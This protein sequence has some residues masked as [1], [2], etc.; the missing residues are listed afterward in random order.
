MVSKEFFKA[1]QEKS[2][3]LAIICLKDSTSREVRDL[4]EFNRLCI[5]YYYKL[6][7]APKDSQD[8]ATIRI[9]ILE[10]VIDRLQ[11]DAKEP[12]RKPLTIEELEQATRNM[13][14]G[15]SLGLN[16]LEFYLKLW[17]TIG[18]EFQFMVW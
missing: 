5:D 9:M 8:Q 10:K 3:S 17:S 18:Q 1:I 15:K 7:L 11:V 4:Q 12:L 14:K 2:L 6:Y 16:A 13:A